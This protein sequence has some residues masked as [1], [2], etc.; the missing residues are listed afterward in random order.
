MLLLTLSLA[1]LFQVA[2]RPAWDGHSL[3]VHEWGTFTTVLD[4]DGVVL[5]GLTHEDGDLPGFV[6]VLGG[7][8]TGASPK[9]ETPVVYVYSP[10]ELELEVDVRFPHGRVTHWYPAASRVN[11]APTPVKRGDERGITPLADGH[12][13]WGRYG[14]LTVLGRRPGQ[15]P[16]RATSEQ[17][18]GPLPVANDDPWRFSRAVAANELRVTRMP[19]TVH[20]AQAPVLE[21][22]PLLFYRGLGDFPLPLRA[23]ALH[24]RHAGSRC[25]VRLVLENDHPDEPLTQLVL[26]CVRDG[27][28][29]FLELP[30]LS[31]PLDLGALSLELEP[32]AHA[33]AKLERCLTTRLVEAG[34]YA[35][36]ALAMAR[37]WRHAW[38]GDEGLRLLYVVPRALV[39]RE[40]PLAARTP[41][42][43]VARREG[44]E[45]RGPDELVR[46][47]V[48][49][50]ELLAPE[51]E[52]EL[53]RIVRDLDHPTAGRRAVAADTVRGWGRFALP[54]VDCV[55]ERAS[56][57]ALRTRAA[58][59][60]EE[61]LRELSVRPGPGSAVRPAGRR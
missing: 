19:W 3:V 6:H 59:L 4:P 11:G 36:E 54:Y 51:A 2:A 31:S 14:E 7:G 52:R 30:D 21:H 23:R 32:L 34:L 56:T 42:A 25:T 40:L 20:G 22:E 39:D 47:F 27:R 16:T 35:D 61:L 33:S 53:E 48:A 50:T 45:S 5:D 44:V 26:V 13:S 55:R 18:V 17:Y 49:R 43:F 28:A 29:G 38:F 10:K 24:E 60:R 46:V 8:L 37:T 12:V 9:M 41:P 57:S 58:E 15:Q 1:A